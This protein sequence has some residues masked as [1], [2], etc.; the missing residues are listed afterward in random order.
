MQFCERLKISWIA[1]FLQALHAEHK[2]NIIWTDV[3]NCLCH[4]SYFLFDACL[5]EDFEFI[6]V[7][8]VYIILYLKVNSDISLIRRHIPNRWQ[9]VI[10]SNEGHHGEENCSLAWRRERGSDIE[11]GFYWNSALKQQLGQWSLFIT[12][13]HPLWS[14]V[15]YYNSEDAFTNH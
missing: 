13:W 5:S 2:T 15:W 3:C 6:F 12:D 8:C 7:I 11:L 10:L 1:F 9:K 14:V 4:L